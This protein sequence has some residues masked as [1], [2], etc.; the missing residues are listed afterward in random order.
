MK[1]VFGKIAIA[2]VITLFTGSTFAKAPEKLEFTCTSQAIGKIGI[3]LSQPNSFGSPEIVNYKI[4]SQRYDRQSG[5]LLGSDEYP[6]DVHSN[7]AIATFSTNDGSVSLFK[8]PTLYIKIPAFGVNWAQHLT[9][10]YVVAPSYGFNL[11]L[12]VKSN[13]VYEDYSKAEMRTFQRNPQVTVVMVPG[14]PYS[15]PQDY[16]AGVKC[17]NINQWQMADEITCSVT[18][19]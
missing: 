5:Q 15:E 18:N 12:G 7:D 16:L 2:T 10:C 19:R 13:T 11:T 3:T 8:E 14:Y 9:D 1:N 6:I 4:T 17:P